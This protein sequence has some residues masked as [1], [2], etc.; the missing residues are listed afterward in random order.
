MFEKTENEEKQLVEV[1]EQPQSLEL[2]SVVQSIT[3]FTTVQKQCEQDGVLLLPQVTRP[4]P[5]VVSNG[6]SIALHNTICSCIDDR[7]RALSDALHYRN[8]AKRLHVEKRE[9]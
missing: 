4:S 2:T 7:D 3:D 5:T 6:D 9:I 8:L 1:P